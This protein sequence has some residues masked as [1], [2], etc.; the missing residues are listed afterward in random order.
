MGA[1]GGDEW[2]AERDVAAGGV[3]DSPMLNASIEIHDTTLTRVE[4]HGQAITLSMQAY[5]HRSDGRPMRDSGTGWSQVVEIEFINATCEG[6]VSKLP[7][8]LL[9]GELQIDDR[10]YPNEIPLPFNA[11]GSVVLRL[12]LDGVHHLLIRGSRASA[13]LIGDARFVENVP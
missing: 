5:I 2:G 13:R 7:V 9:E 6:N 3:T 12:Q 11:N 4:Q 10:V 1:P 8:D